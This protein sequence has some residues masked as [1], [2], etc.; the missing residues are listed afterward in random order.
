MELATVPLLRG[1]LDLNVIE[2]KNWKFDPGVV[3]ANYLLSDGQLPPSGS[4]PLIPVSMI[5]VRN[6]KIS[7]DMKS[8]RDSY[9]MEQVRG[10][11]S[12][13]W[14]PFSIRA[15]YFRRTDKTTHD[16]VEDSAGITIPGMQ[17]IGFVC[18]L[19]DKTPDPDPA[20]N[21]P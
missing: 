2:S 3:G 10:S 11:A 7:F 1:W 15:N 9:A 18:R 19:L 20:L 4:M 6:V 12:A 16:F 17:L 13:G 21:W 8:Q 14:G 5:L